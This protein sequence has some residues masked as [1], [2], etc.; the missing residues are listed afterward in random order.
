MRHLWLI[1]PLRGRKFPLRNSNV[2]MSQTTCSDTFRCNVGGFQGFPYVGESVNRQKNQGRG[3]GCEIEAKLRWRVNRS[4][5]AYREVRDREK[6]CGHD[7]RL[8]KC[9]R[10]FWKCPHKVRVWKVL[11]N[12]GHTPAANESGSCWSVL[13]S[14]PTRQQHSSSRLSGRLAYEGAGLSLRLRKYVRHGPEGSG[15]VLGM[16]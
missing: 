3:V 2:H 1:R 7:W 15:K 14:Q 4:R 11:E 10:R 13:V 8:G 9:S 16:F 6:V 12:P 5:I